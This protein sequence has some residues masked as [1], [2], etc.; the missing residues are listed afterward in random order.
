MK[1]RENYHADCDLSTCVASGGTRAPSGV[2]HGESQGPRGVD[3]QSASRPV[4]KYV[5]VRICSSATPFREWGIERQLSALHDAVP[6][7]REGSKAVDTM[8]GASYI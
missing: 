7:S 1:T 5:I 2:A 4:G 8:H 6:G 3:Q